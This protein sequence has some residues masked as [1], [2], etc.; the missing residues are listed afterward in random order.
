M[1]IMRTTQLFVLIM[2]AAAGVIALDQMYFSGQLVELTNSYL[3]LI[4]F[5][6]LI[7]S[8]FSNRRTPT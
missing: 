2:V 1:S 3:V 5:A 6:S 7:L 4:L 8:I